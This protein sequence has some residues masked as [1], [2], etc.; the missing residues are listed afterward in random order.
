LL[1]YRAQQFRFNLQDRKDLVEYLVKNFGPDAKPRNVRT[2]QETPLDE[3]KLG[4]AMFMEYYVPQ[5][6]PGQGVN[7]PEYTGPGGRP[8]TRR[9]QDVRFDTDGNVYGS[10]RGTPR[11]LI[12]L[13]PRTGEW[14]GGGRRPPQRPAA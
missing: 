10:D 11:R 9:I 12:K 6:A 3:V 2:V 8:G 14:R 13:N 5:D 7:A 1:N 4:K